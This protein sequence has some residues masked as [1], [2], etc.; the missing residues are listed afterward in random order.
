MFAQGLHSRFRSIM[1]GLNSEEA[2]RFLTRKDKEI[3]STIVAESIRQINDCTATTKPDD[4]LTLTVSL[5]EEES[6]RLCDESEEEF[7]DHYLTVLTEQAENTYRRI[8][9]FEELQNPHSRAKRI[10]NG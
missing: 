7:C 10:R 6:N 4:I 8:Q 2:A 3:D 9:R 1:I 5:T